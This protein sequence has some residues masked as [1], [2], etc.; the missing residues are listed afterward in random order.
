MG[1]W[2]LPEKIP[3]LKITSGDPIP[4]NILEINISSR[5]TTPFFD[6]CFSNFNWGS[7]KGKI[8][9]KK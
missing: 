6:K 2:G 7:K 1:G 8:F 5:N 3:I 4:I 9:F